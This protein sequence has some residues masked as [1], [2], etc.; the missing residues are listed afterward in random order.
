MIEEIPERIWKGELIKL[1]FKDEIDW[2]EKTKLNRNGINGILTFSVSS[3]SS[4]TITI[5]GGQTL[6]CETSI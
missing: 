2:E 5:Y 4:S 6:Y 1:H 3:S